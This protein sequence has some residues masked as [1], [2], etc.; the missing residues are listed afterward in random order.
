MYNTFYRD[1]YSLRCAEHITELYITSR[2]YRRRY[3]NSERSFA[4]LLVLILLKSVH[5]KSEPEVA[6]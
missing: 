5:A 4:Q 2:R 6:F 3:S 1:P